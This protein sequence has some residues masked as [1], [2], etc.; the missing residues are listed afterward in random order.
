MAKMWLDDVI[1]PSLLQGI[2]VNKPVP[3][4]F[5]IDW[6]GGVA[7]PGTAGT[8]IGSQWQCQRLRWIHR[9]RR[10]RFIATRSFPD[11]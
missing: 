11:V 1:A 4:Q 5:D 8:G 2:D 9:R 3:P 6:L 7:R 10:H